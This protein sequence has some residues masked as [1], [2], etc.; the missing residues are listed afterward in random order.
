MVS[1]AERRIEYLPLVGLV[2]ADTNPK[3]HRLDLLRSSIDRFGFATPALRDER[4]GRLVVGHGRTNTLTVM[5]A[6]GESPPD[7]IEVDDTGGWLVPVVVGWSSRSDAEA[8]AYLIADNR[9][10]ELGGWDHNELTDLLGDLATTDADLV[11]VAG[12][13][14]AELADLLKASQPVNLD[15]L[16]DSLGAP[17]AVDGFANIAIRCAP[18]VAEAW[19]SHLSTVGEDTNAAL[20][21]LLGV[22][23]ELLAPVWSA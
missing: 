19:R 1:I 3:R 16:A 12:W 2:P 14:P 6:A 4:T 15:A 9:H 17:A 13:D 8:S 18:H 20:A 10:S 5:H 21:Q 7:G 22:D 23:A 11:A